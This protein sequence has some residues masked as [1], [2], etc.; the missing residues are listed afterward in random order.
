MKVAKSMYLDNTFAKKRP[1]KVP[2]VKR[3]LAGEVIF[4]SFGV[5]SGEIPVTGTE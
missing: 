3:F 1:E 5:Y 2:P 4:T